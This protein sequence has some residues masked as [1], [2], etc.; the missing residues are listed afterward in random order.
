M[1]TAPAMVLLYDRAFLAGSAVEALRKRR[2]L[3]A[4]LCATWLVLLFLLAGSHESATS[5]GVG[6][7][8]PSPWHYLLTQPGVLLHY[9]RLSLWPDALCF[10]YGW[11]AAEGAGGAVLPGLAL[12]ALLLLSVWGSLRRHPAAW[13]GLWVFIILAP[14]SS[15]LPLG[16]CAF[17][18]RMYLPL[19]AVAAGAVVGGHALLHKHARPGLLA[20]LAVTAVAA[21]SALTWQRNEVYASEVSMWRDV[22]RQRPLNLRARNDLAVALSEAGHAG[23]AMREYERVLGMIPPNLRRRLDAGQVQLMGVVPPDAPE[24][25]YFRARVNLGVMVY[26]L[27]GDTHAAIEHLE[28]ALRVI[29]Y[30]EDVGEMLSFIRAGAACTGDR[31]KEGAAR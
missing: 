22:V 3:Y 18:H 4:S 30:R 20:A 19:A 31:P 15:L 23:E 27:Q 25:S 6:G 13:L 26:T 24:Y 21:L 7:Y 1:V 12:A 5:A 29:P 17:E 11:P 2:G 10:D 14:T 28:A 16:D 8:L 9:L